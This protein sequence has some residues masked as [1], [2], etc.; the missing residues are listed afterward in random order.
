MVKNQLIGSLN[1]FLQQTDKPNKE[2][3]YV[4]K[5]DLLETSALLDE[6]KS[7]DQNVKLKDNSFYKCYLGNV[8]K[9]DDNNYVVQISYIWVSPKARRF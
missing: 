4:L 5:E 2:N 1:G 9:Q 8:V 3:K 7:M 6:I